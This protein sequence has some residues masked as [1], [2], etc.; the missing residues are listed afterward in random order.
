MRKPG[1]ANAATGEEASKPAGLDFGAKFGMLRKGPNPAPEIVQPNQQIL[2]KELPV[3]QPVKKWS[4]P[5]SK[6]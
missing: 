3:K 1:G 2:A 6:M 5:K 4:N